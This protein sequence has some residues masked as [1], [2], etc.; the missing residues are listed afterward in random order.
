[1][2]YIGSTDWYLEHAK[3]VV[4]ST[5][6]DVISYDDKNKDLNKFGFTAQC[7]TTSTEIQ[8]LPA[9][10]FS[11]TDIYQNLITTV[12]GD[13][14]ADTQIVTLEGHTVGSDVSVSTLTQAAGVATCT[15][16]A[17][18]GHTTGDWVYMSGANEAGYNGI[19]QVTVTSTTIFT[20]TV[21]AATAS[22]ATGTILSTNQNLTFVTQNVQLNGQTQVTLVTPLAR[23]TRFVVPQQNRASSITGTIYA[24]ETDTTTAGIPDTDA[25]VHLMNGFNGSINGSL[26]GRTAISS[27]DYWIITSFHAHYEEKS[28]GFATVILQKR[29]PG[30]VWLEIDDVSVS[31]SS[32][33]AAIEFKP[34]QIIPANYDV[35]LVGVCDV[36]N[37]EVAGSIEG[38][39]AKII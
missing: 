33:T 16:G 22:P 21:D 34:Y 3:R 1:M 7:Q 27:T 24:Y 9:G 14:V 20:Y 35:R 26:K 11:E 30:G 29:A 8:R 23:S 28:S 18:H 15:T 10:T 38:V 36:N 2:S 13:K 25:K 32:N 31:A 19:V 37:K 5:Y 12:S 6:G 17:V 4:E 39:L